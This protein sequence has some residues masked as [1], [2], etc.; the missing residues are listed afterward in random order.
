MEKADKS[1]Y[2]KILSRPDGRRPN[3]LDELATSYPWLDGKD[4][5]LSIK[6]LNKCGGT[7]QIVWTEKQANEAAKREAAKNEN[8]TK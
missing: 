1:R 4:M 2:D 5:V 3:F 6:L 8:K 7:S